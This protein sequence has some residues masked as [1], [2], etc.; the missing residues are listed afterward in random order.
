MLTLEQV[1]RGR[2][3]R[4]VKPLEKGAAQMRLRPIR[5]T[6]TC[7]LT[8]CQDWRKLMGYVLALVVVCT[9]SAD[10]RFKIS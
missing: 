1:A 3:M 9:H 8:S 4:V 6:M 5:R 10:C 2:D 7:M